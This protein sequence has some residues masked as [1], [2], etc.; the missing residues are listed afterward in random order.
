LIE[1]HGLDALKQ[2]L[3]DLGDGLNINDALV[4]SAG[5][6]QK[7]DSQFADYAREHAEDFGSQADWS[8]EE[9]PE[10]PTT[11][12][13]ADWVD[14]HPT[15]YWG[16]RRLGEAYVAA[17]DFEKAKTPLQEL[18]SLE[19]VTGEQGGP[20]ELLASVYRELEDEAAERET[21]ETIISLSS[22]ALPA[23][24]RLIEMERAE[25]KWGLIDR[26]A[27]R[28][29]SIN[30]LLPEGHVAIAEAAEQLDR[31][32]DVVQSLGALAQMDPV[33]PAALNYRLAGA[34]AEL[35][36]IDRAK[37]HV[38]RA[39]DEAPRYREA[40]RL[41]L[42]LNEQASKLEVEAS[43]KPEDEATSEPE[44]VDNSKDEEKV[45]SQ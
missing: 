34:L 24:R 25:D 28:V 11:T 12:E 20:L 37:H 23:L 10:K 4:R 29:T 30:P 13:L 7:L 26:Y 19:T 41:L 3:D 6:L 44:S 14:Q 2:I 33:D 8:R 36:Q 21:L 5:S 31:P 17:G 15:N 9:L 35:N 45:E 43:T 1:Q 40:H 32:S 27:Q 38:L 39:L 16:L 42:A 22:D 18:R